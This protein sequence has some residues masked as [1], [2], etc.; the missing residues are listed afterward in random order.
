MLARTPEPWDSA[1]PD[2]ASQ[3]RGWRLESFHW[4][5]V[6]RGGI[7]AT[8]DRAHPFG[9]QTSGGRISWMRMK[10]DDRTSP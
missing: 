3:L 8:T 2:V 7:F 4:R 9:T 6:S 10:G 5:A 1:E